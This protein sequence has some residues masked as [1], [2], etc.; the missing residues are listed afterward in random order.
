MGGCLLVVSAVTGVSYWTLARAILP[1]VL[2]EIVVLGILI[3]F[4]QISLF[5]PQ[6]FGF[7][8]G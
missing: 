8:G 7:A 4:P 1:F 3:A 6:Y 5:L 2:V